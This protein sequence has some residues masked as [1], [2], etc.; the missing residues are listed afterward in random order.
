MTKT[1]S[2]AKQAS[3]MNSLIFWPHQVLIWPLSYLVEPSVLW[4]AETDAN[5]GIQCV[6]LDAWEELQQRSCFNE[7]WSCTKRQEIGNVLAW[8]VD[9]GLTWVRAAGPSVA[10]CPPSEQVRRPRIKDQKSGSRIKD[11]ESRIRNQSWALRSCK[12]PRCLPRQTLGG[13]KCLKGSS[14]LC[15][16]LGDHH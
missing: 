2:P 7:E 3:L 13:G 12:G 9:F 6:Q 4:H 11:Q 14:F 1:W 5:G 8:I 15:C 16:T 10:T